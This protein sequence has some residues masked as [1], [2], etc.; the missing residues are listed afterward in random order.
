[1]QNA[2][3]MSKKH[4]KDLKKITKVSK[5]IQKQ[6][7]N[8]PKI[9]PRISQKYLKSIL[10]VS[11]KY[12]K[13]I[14][15]ASQTYPKSIITSSKQCTSSLQPYLWLGCTK[16]LGLILGHILSHVF[17]SSLGRQTCSNQWETVWCFSYFVPPYLVKP[18]EDTLIRISEK[19]CCVSHFVTNPKGHAHN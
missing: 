2:L 9:I 12:P 19:M 5:I 17:L 7:K 3:N 15:K 10:K 8:Y 13:S 6:S 18:K 1:M 14:P 4:K 11:Q 16:I